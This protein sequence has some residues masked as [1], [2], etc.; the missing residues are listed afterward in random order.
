MTCKSFLMLIVLVVPLFAQYGFDFSC[1]DDTMK[2]IGDTTTIVE[3]Y[4]R[5]EN[6]GSVPDSFAFDCRI[7]DSIPG[8]EELFC[9]GGLCAVPGIILYDYLTAGQ[10]DTNIDVT[11]YPG[12]NYGVEV[13]NL[14]V[15]SVGNPV[16]EDSI[17]VI[18]EKVS[19]IEEADE[20]NVRHGQM[21]AF[22]NPFSQLTTVNFDVAQNA[23]RILLNIYD[24]VGGLVKSFSM[25]SSV[26]GH[27]A[28]VRWDGTDQIN[29][30]LPNGVYFLKLTA[31]DY[32]VTKK[33]LLIR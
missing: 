29:R 10:V 14:K 28:S 33:V 3:F 11:V 5:L 31:G 30:S 20:I 1:L 23:E 26:I 27:Q 19:A 18:V 32:S 13:L 6:V 12:S 16:L 24:A 9:A 22:P 7:I 8:W 25:P 15:H 17:S 4:F 21:R 2:I